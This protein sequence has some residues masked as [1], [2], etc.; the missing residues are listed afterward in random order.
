ML[1]VESEPR[2]PASNRQARARWFP[3]A[4]LALVA[5]VC[6][7]VQVSGEDQDI[8]NTAFMLC[9]AA[10]F[11]GWSTWQILCGG[12]P[13]AQRLI[14]GVIPWVTAAAF[15][16]SVELVNNG[17]IG[18]VG[19]RWRWGAKPDEKLATPHVANT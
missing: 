18:I 6:L 19:W 14:A 2:A 4:W 17:D 16:S 10:F 1:P 9:L 7:A 8:K 15:F 13:L 3:L 11:L 5:V 12:R